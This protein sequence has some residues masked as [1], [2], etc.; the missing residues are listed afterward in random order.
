M[1]AQR[2]GRDMH[3]VPSSSQHSRAWMGSGLFIYLHSDW[4]SAPTLA[5][6]MTASKLLCLLETQFP[7]LQNGNNNYFLGLLWG[8]NID[9]LYFIALYQALWILCFLKKLKICGNPASS[10][11][12]G[13]IFPTAFVPFVPLC[14]ILVIFT[15]FQ[16]FGY[17]YICDHWSLVLLL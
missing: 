17:Y 13:A 5:T 9:I 6:H 15:I 4:I 14:H 3:E 1:K 12:I 10:K 11:S 16:T 7:D 8:L 2:G